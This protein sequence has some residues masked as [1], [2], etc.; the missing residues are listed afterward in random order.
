MFRY[1]NYLSLL[2]VGLVSSLLTVHA[3][4][5]LRHPRFLAPDAH[6]PYRVLVPKIGGACIVVACCM[7][8]A[9]ALV[10]HIA[11]ERLLMTLAATA[12]MGLVGLLDDVLGLR[13]LFRIGTSVILASAV[14]ALDYVSHIVFP[15]GYIH[16]MVMISALAFL[17]I[18]ILTNA[19]NMLDIMNGIVSGSVLM[20]CASLTIICLI[21]HKPNAALTYLVMT[22]ACA[23]LFA[24]NKYPAKVFNGNVGSYALG[25]FLGVAAACYGTYVETVLAGLPYIINGMLILFSTRGRVFFGGRER[26]KRPIFCY[27]G[28]LVP[29]LDPDA[30]LTLARLAVL[31]GCRDEK[32]VVESILKMF[33]VC[34]LLTVVLILAFTYLRLH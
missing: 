15:L 8:V 13:P 26:A 34:A 29:N 3:V 22:L 24:Y 30:P 23:P 17:S 27:S 10:L 12:L 18:V 2:L 32:C 4:S 7:T 11:D 20:M 21:E 25:A 19:V 9:T 28:R 6:K 33:L 16:N 31:A 1:L 14:V 5:R